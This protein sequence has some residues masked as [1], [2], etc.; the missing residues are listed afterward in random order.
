[1]KTLNSK[2]QKRQYSRFKPVYHPAMAAKVL[3]FYWCPCTE[4]PHKRL[5]SDAQE[6][7]AAAAAIYSSTTELVDCPINN[8]QLVIAFVQ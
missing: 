5:P 1:M 4:P 3:L 8:R 6:G 7:A 2:F